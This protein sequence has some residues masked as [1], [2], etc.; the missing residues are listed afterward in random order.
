M[1]D[2]LT[3]VGLFLRS[4]ET[5]VSSERYLRGQSTSKLTQV[6]H[7]NATHAFDICQSGVSFLQ[8]HSDVLSFVSG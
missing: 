4:N 6:A 1:I 7:Q 3:I 2:N 5:I 8:R